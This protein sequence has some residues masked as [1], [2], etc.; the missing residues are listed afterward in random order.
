M[1]PSV[2]LAHKGWLMLGENHRPPSLL[3]YLHRLPDAY[4]QT[5]ERFTFFTIMENFVISTH[6]I[7]KQQA[8]HK[9]FDSGRIGCYFSKATQVKKLKNCRWI[10]FPKQGTSRSVLRPKGYKAAFPRK[11]TH[12]IHR[13][14]DGNN[15]KHFR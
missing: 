4:A 11:G 2:N 12:N 8:V 1:F 15:W 3:S 9:T 5:Y 6:L 13:D 14:C 10:T 7:K